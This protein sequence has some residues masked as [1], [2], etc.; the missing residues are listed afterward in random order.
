MSSIAGAVHP[1]SRLRLLALL[2]L[3]ALL[4]ACSSSSPEEDRTFRESGIV[5]AHPFRATYLLESAEPEAQTVGCAVTTQRYGPLL[6][7]RADAYALGGEGTLR[8]LSD[9]DRRFLAEIQRQRAERPLNTVPEATD[10]LD[11]FERSALEKELDGDVSLSV[12]L[13]LGYLANA[14]RSEGDRFQ[15]W[16]QVYDTRR[17]PTFMQ[18]ATRELFMIIRA[19]RGRPPAETPEAARS[20]EDL[21]IAG[22]PES[23]ACLGWTARFV[24]VSPEATQGFRTAYRW[25]FCAL[26]AGLFVYDL[27]NETRPRLWPPNPVPGE[28][29][30]EPWSPDRSWF[31]S[32]WASL[33]G[34]ADQSGPGSGGSGTGASAAGGSAAGGSS[35]TDADTVDDLGRAARVGTKLVPKQRVLDGLV[36][37]PDADVGG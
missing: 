25:D 5:V 4:P 37:V 23:H 32:L 17:Q 12:A 3:L 24:D 35:G 6:P 8:L 36:A 11:R 28:S 18:K 20:L 7:Q 29:G 9:A 15:E 10:Y 19:S 34:S 27:L 26:E 31:G 22:E 14:Y 1:A 16:T 21:K 2:M 13:C 30:I 33:T